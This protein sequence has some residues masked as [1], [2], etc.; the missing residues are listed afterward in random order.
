[1]SNT[2]TSAQLDTVFAGWVALAIEAGALSEHLEA[3]REI[4]LVTG[5]KYY[6][7]AFGVVAVDRVTGGQ[8]TL[9]HLGYTKREAYV[10]LS[11]QRSAWLAA[12][13]GTF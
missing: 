12:E 10:I 13:R 11:A 8:S 4:R 9:V 1:M 5:S 3:N 2:I 7:N 6:G